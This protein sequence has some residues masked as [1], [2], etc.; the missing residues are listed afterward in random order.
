MGNE[1][2][3]W[4]W[5][6]GVSRPLEGLF[7]P[8]GMHDFSLPSLTCLGTLWWLA[9][10]PL[11]SPPL[12]KHTGH[13]QDPK[14]AFL[15]VAR[16]GRLGNAGCGGSRASLGGGA[17]EPSGASSPLPQDVLSLWLACCFLSAKLSIPL[18]N[19]PSACLRLERHVTDP[20]TGGPREGQPVSGRPPSSVT[21][22]LGTGWLASPGG[23]ETE[24]G[25]RTAP[26]GC[27]HRVQ[28]LA[29]AL[30][31]VLQTAA[32]KQC[33]MSHLESALCSTDI[34]QGSFSCCAWLRLFPGH[35]AARHPSPIS[36]GAW[37]F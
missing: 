10:C 23:T 37:R 20:V 4:F 33:L 34:F 18:P 32:R 27:V 15:R 3:P 12:R 5:T 31:G 28:C 16:L 19:T 1:W 8:Q 2:V 25:V 30:L 6:S 11:P 14:G 36:K 24:R 22:R 7:N 13:T 26:F 21:C 35:R 29:P 17:W 9:R